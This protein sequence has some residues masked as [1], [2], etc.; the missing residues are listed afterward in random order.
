MNDERRRR[1][2]VELFD[3][4][5]RIRTG[6]SW[7]PV[8]LID[9]SL[10]GARFQLDWS[11]MVGESLELELSVP[12]H[13]MVLQS[14]VAWSHRATRTTGVEFVSLSRHRQAHVN[15]ALL[16][17]WRCYSS[18]GHALIVADDPD[19][20]IEIAT[21][22]LAR[23]LAVISRSTPLDALDALEGTTPRLV[24]AAATLPNNAARD[25]L[26]YCADEYPSVPTV[27]L[28]NQTDLGGLLD[29]LLEE[30]F[31]DYAMMV[32]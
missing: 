3:Q 9:A 24:I 12:C 28:S 17:T 14:T 11:P 19:R 32:G 10:S 26:G 8:E 31:E 6:G 1:R 21:E 30:S 13:L 23:G 18:H 7:L 2:R 5:A 22:I 15:N 25:L 16:E 27:L 29:R 20:Q 4:R